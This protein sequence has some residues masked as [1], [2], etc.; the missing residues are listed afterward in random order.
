MKTLKTITHMKKN[1]F[2]AFAATIVLTFA[3]CSAYAPKDDGFYNEVMTGE[4]VAN[5]SGDQFEEFADNPFILTSEEPTSTF[6][7]DADGASYAYMRSYISEGRFPDKSSVRIEE[8]LNYFTFDYP[9][10]TDAVGINAEVGACPWNPDHYL[11]RLGLKG[12]SVAMENMVPAN[13]VFLVDVSGSMSS[14]NKLPLLKSAL[15]TLV[16]ELNPTDRVSLITYSGSVQCLLESTEAMH[17]GEIKSAIRSL[18][19]GGSTAGGAAMQMAYDEA[20]RNYIVGGN[21][22]I[23][24][25]TDGDFNVGVT[26]TD[27]LLNMVSR[28]ADQGIYLTMCGFGT[29]NWNDA[30]M[31]KVSNR[32][33]GTYYYIDCED[34]FMKIFVHDRM[35]LQAVANDTKCQVTFNPSR[36]AQYRLIGYEN[37]VMSNEDFDDDTKDAG[38]I[39]AGQ[40]ITALYEI[41]PTDIQTAEP[42]PYATFDCRYKE[43]LG[44]S[45]KKLSLDIYGDIKSESDNLNFAAGL[46]AYGMLLRNSE[47]KGQSSLIMVKA[48]IGNSLSFDPHGYRADLLDLLNNLT[49]QQIEEFRQRELK[50]E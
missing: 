14:D 40:T 16:D 39:G 28:Y 18:S 23:I 4:P 30:M 7:I 8:F 15:L 29:G 38:E 46:A 19:A 42:I 13:Y 35:Q 50:V 12:K 26:N 36:V 49:E 1:S 10:P 27:S 20:L 32:G 41:V 33:N 34:E 31:E 22:R 9:E 3:A 47:Y 21:N 43:Q 11:L 6:S 48:L 37:R 44:L 24:M 5:T 17:A 25:G 45:S 2:G